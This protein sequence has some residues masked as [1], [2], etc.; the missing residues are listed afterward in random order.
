MNNRLKQGAMRLVKNALIML[1][2]MLVIVT[3][4]FAFSQRAFLFGMTL[5]LLLPIGFIFFF[6]SFRNRLANT[7]PLIILF[8]YLLYNSLY[9]RYTETLYFFYFMPY[10]GLLIRKKKTAVK[11]S[12]TLLTTIVLILRFFF[13]FDIPFVTRALLI[14]LI[15]IVFIPPAIFKGISHLKEKIKNSSCFLIDLKFIIC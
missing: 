1:I 6:G 14:G 2:L 4:F 12:T 9:F 3:S 13:D 7:L 10:I 8:I 15:Y 5:Y 11:I